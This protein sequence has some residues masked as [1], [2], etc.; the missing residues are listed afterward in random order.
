MR[1]NSI[2]SGVQKLVERPLKIICSLTA[3]S[4]SNRQSDRY[5]VKQIV[6]QGQSDSETVR[7]TVRQ[8][9]RQT[10]I[11]KLTDSGKWQTDTGQTV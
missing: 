9:N 4:H 2:A 10:A 8:S 3:D 1:A 7:H 11:D 5:R 6:S